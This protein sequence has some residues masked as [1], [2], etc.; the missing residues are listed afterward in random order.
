MSGKQTV[1]AKGRSQKVGCNQ[2]DHG[3]AKRSNNEVSV[4]LDAAQDRMENTA[5]Y[6]QR[7]K[8]KL[9]ANVDLH[10]FEDFGIGSLV[11]KESADEF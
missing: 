9:N 11:D 7:K 10:I 8:G 2:V 1:N 3:T 6:M 5:E 4:R